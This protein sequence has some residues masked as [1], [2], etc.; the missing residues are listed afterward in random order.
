M[1][2][3]KVSLRSS[4]RDRVRDM[5]RFWLGPGTQLDPTIDTAKCGN[6]FAV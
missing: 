6:F 1:G 2:R 4:F 3:V 5:V